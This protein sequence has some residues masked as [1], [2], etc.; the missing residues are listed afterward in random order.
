[1]QIPKCEVMKIMSL[2]LLGLLSTSLFAKEECALYELKGKVK[3][4]NYFLHLIVAEKT[5]SE[6]TLKIPVMIQAK[7]SPYVNRFIQGQFVVE[8]KEIQTHKKILQV[9]KIDFA[10]NDPLN[11][12]QNTA[13]KKL[14]EIS[15]SGQ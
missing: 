9:Q 14:K 5:G 4:I 8:G 15:C 1:M 11:Q 2:L 10:V 7:F 3:S 13:S 12:N 6:K